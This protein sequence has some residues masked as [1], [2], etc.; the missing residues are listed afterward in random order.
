MKSL[1]A[2]IASIACAA[3]SQGI[4]AQVISWI[5][6][7]SSS[8]A[9][10]AT[11][12]SCGNR[13]DEAFERLGRPL[14]P[15]ADA[16]RANVEEALDLI[17]DVAVIETDGGELQRRQGDNEPSVT[18]ADRPLS[19]S[20]P[21]APARARRRARARAPRPSRAAPARCPTGA[22]ARGPHRRAR[23][24]QLLRARLTT[25]LARQSQPRRIGTLISRCGNI[26]TG[27][28]A[29]ASVVRCS[30]S[31]RSTAS[32]ATIASPVVCLSRQDQVAG[33]LA[34][35]EPALLDE[36]LEHVAVADPRALERDA[37]LARAPARSRGSTSACRRRRRHARRAAGSP[38]R[39]RTAAGRR[40]RRG[41][42]ASTISSRSPSPS[43][44]MPRSRRVRAAP[45]RRGTA[46][47]SR[48]RRR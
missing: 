11:R 1:P 47:A 37:G 43:S 7:S 22:A 23:R 40:R 24:P 41:R 27:A 19:R 46:D 38:S 35:E 48:R 14:R 13:V 28:V 17:V 12:G 29:S 36:L 34:A 21:R 44:A 9:R 3:R 42:R 31:A 8:R 39:S 4:A 10:S 33:V 15:V 26:C 2:R 32:A 5:D 45:A 18:A 30:I 16:L 6:A 25:S 20:S